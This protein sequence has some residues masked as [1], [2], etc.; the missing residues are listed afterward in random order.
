MEAENQKI[1]VNFASLL[2]GSLKDLHT[3]II[4]S[5]S[6]Q[7]KQL[8]CMEDHVCSHLASKSDVRK[9]KLILFQL[10]SLFAMTVH[11]LI[12]A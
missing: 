9:Q 3:T 6:Q 12:F 8:K 7:Q 1:I 5:I 10:Q 11:H 2:N 4:G